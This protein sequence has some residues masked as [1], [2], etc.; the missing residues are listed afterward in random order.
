MPRKAADS[1][2]EFP[3]WGP[4]ELVRDG[5]G[6]GSGAGRQGATGGNLLPE[7]AGTKLHLRVHGLGCEGGFWPTSSEV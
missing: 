4:W 2:S 5:A 3:F 6:D 7:S 1:S